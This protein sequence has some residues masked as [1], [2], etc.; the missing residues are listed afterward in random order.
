M[1]LILE[2]ENYYDRSNKRRVIRNTLW[3][4]WSHLI[5]SFHARRS[6]LK[7]AILKSPQVQ[8]DSLAYHM[9]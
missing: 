9:S 5:V 7:L 2:N 1:E 8:P 3:C 4:I 6:G